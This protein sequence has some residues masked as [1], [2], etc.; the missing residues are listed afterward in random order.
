[1]EM[2]RG[3]TTFVIVFRRPANY[4]FIRSELNGNVV[5]VRPSNRGD[6][7]LGRFVRKLKPSKSVSL[8]C[9]H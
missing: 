3:Y 1:M 9:H 4:F 5:E 6:S 7:W 2:E 8:G